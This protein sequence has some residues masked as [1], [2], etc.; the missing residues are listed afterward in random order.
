MTRE[1]ILYELLKQKRPTIGT[2]VHTIWPGLV[3]VI[4]HSGVIDYVEFTADYA[5]YDLQSL[6]NFGRA[7]DLFDHM[8][9]MMKIE[10]HLRP[11]LAV[12]AIGSGIQ[13]LNFADIRN[14]D[15]AK[16]AVA[17]SRAATPQAGGMVGVRMARDVG[18]VVEPGSVNYVESLERVVVVL[19]IENCTAVEHLEDILSVE[20]ISMVQF[21]P[22]D[23]SMSIGIPGQWD[24]VEVKR[25]ELHMIETALKMG[26]A[27]RVE[28]DQFE[29]AEPYIELGVKDFSIGQDVTIISDYCLDQGGKLA[30]ILGK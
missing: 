29:D 12:R 27:P 8:S 13:N 15:D 14:A 25:A 20:G 10:E 19:H 18:Y 24:H 30:N 26:I 28:I 23:Y 6:E 3:E 11:Y 21:G 2:R 16:Q 1:N 9:G 4:G 22:A 7:I 5:P 17:S